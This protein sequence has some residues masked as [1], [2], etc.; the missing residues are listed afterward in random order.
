MP[1]LASVS[2]PN[3]QT[4]NFGFFGNTNDQG[5]QTI[6]NKKADGSTIS[7][8][9]YTYDLNAQ[10]Q[11]WTQQV[12][13]GAPTVWNYGYDPANQLLD[14]TLWSTGVG[15]SILK[16]F[17]YKY[18]PSGNRLS[19][20][21]NGG[22]SK[23]TH[24]AA[25]QILAQEGGGSVRFQGS[26]NEPASLMVN[27]KAVSV[28][29]NGAF[30]ADVDGQIGTNVI[31][32]VATDYNGNVRTN[33]YELVITNSATERM[34]QYDLN[35][36]MTR[37]ASS[38]STNTYEWVAVNRLIAIEITESGN[39]LKR[40][41]F[42]YDGLGRRVRILEKENGTTISNKRYIWS[43]HEI[44]EE[45]DSTTGIV[46]KRFFSYGEQIAGTNYFFTRD[47]LGSVREMTD[48][49][50]AL[51]ARYEYDPYGRRS[52]ILGDQ[53]AD[54]A[55]TG[56][57]NHQVSGL[58]LTLYR[59]YDSDSGR[60]LN[61]DPIG[62]NGGLN[63][64]GFVG[65]NPVRWVDPYGLDY[66][67]WWDPRTWFNSGFTDS[68]YDSSNSIGEGLGNALAGDWDG[69]GDAYD[70]GVLGQ[71]KDA[72]PFTKYG[73]RVCIGTATAA[74]SGAAALMAAEGAFG[75]QTRIAAHG[76]HH[77][78]PP[79]GR[80]PHAQLNWWRAGVKGSGGAIR[81]PVP[82]GTPGFPP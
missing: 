26:V 8:F 36:N 18:D 61:R 35:G 12:D 66:G 78:F 29:T 44:A 2:Y 67:D 13:N 16:Q 58:Q 71:T 68:W 72:D 56:Y 43:G 24:N 10:I 39:P 45:R 9:D 77:S 54:F 19:E 51:R 82:P 60:W 23:Y 34:V 73:T 4:A 38:A 37:V 49:T 65:N 75:L 11:T 70:N 40:S 52:K 6:W 3:G 47:H 22:V 1:R 55:F 41:E 27:G 62:E 63:L 31:P 46:T 14:A 30:T 20:Q 5:L 69:L 33:N 76:S 80:L 74:A 79:F 50:G 7:K 48:G 28:S 17:V 32:V 15:A 42:T 53:D 57:Y 81:F 59:A 25:N 64:Y 21:I